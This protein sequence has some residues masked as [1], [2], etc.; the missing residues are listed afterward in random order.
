MEIRAKDFLEKQIDVK[1]INIEIM[2]DTNHTIP[3]T[4]QPVAQ[5]TVEVVSDAPACEKKKCNCQKCINI[6]VCVLLAAVV[7]LF[8]LFF[9]SNKGSKVNPNATPAIAA[10]GGLKIAYVD[11]DT[12]MAKYQ[13]ALDLNEE[14]VEFR[15]QQEA[16]Y[17]RQMTQFQNDY[18]KYMQDG[19]NMTL[20]QQQ[21]KEAELKSRM[22]K[23]QGL[24]GELALKIQQRTLEE[25]EKMT[26]AVY[27]FIREYNEANQQF[28]LIL[29]K[30]FTS[31]PV[32]YGNEGMDIT[33][34]IVE[35]LNEEYKSVKSK[36]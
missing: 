21:S 8:I 2:E 9:T 16:S 17:K 14:L 6:L 12:L 18:N 35:G 7:A 11:T 23:L 33:N 19:P 4:E 31:T 36:K 5:P 29:A 20:T 27:A 34:E 10:E 15:N 3:A 22:E 30:S 26:R 1:T 32:L 13:Y 28:D 25:S 24:E